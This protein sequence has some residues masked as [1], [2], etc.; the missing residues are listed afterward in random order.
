VSAIYAFVKEVDP[1]TN[2]LLIVNEFVIVVAP[3]ISALPTH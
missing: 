1:P 3:V 2:K